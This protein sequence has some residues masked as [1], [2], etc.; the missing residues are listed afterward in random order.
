MKNKILNP[1]VARLIAVR[2]RR[3]R[4]E[5]GILRAQAIDT[6]ATLN[7][8][9]TTICNQFMR[10]PSGFVAEDLFP[11][12]PSAMQSAN[13]YV[14]TAAELAQVPNLPGRAPG[15]AYPRLKQTLSSDSFFCKDYG[16]EGPVADE[17]RQKYATYFDADLSTVRRLVDTIRVNREQRVY[18]LV[19]GGGAPSAAIAVPWND[20]T[21]NPKGDVDAARE[22]IRQN[23]GLMPNLLVITQPMLNVLSIHPKLLD[24]FKYTVPGV[25]DEDRLAAYFQIQKVKIAKN[26]IATNNEGQAFTP[27]DIWGNNAVLAHTNSA[28]DLMVPNFGRT[29]HWTAFTSQVSI[30]TGGTGPAM[31]TGGGGP[32]LMQVFSYRDETVK[33][34]IHRTEHYVGEKLTA[35]N[36]GFVLQN[37]LR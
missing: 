33:S 15:S 16:I 5:H 8:I 7:P 36:A 28:A 32:D 37:P 12:F 3:L 18:A 25:L 26:V 35:T 34:D 20:A 2:D 11:S 1:V 30:N 29:F 27:A 13:Y 9:L 31:T 17:D 10:D 22:S 4:E 21:S 14:F 6:S 19:T 24:V 23:I